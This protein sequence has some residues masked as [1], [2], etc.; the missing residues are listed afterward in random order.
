MQPLIQDILMRLY[1]ALR[2]VFCHFGYRTAHEICLFVAQAEQFS[3]S[4]SVQLELLDH[5]IYGKILPKIRGQSSQQ[6]RLALEQSEEICTPCCPRSAEK[7]R[8]MRQRLEQAGLTR[9]WT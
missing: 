7:I 1:K 9:F 6:M 3:N 2:P 5:G 8:S 4:E